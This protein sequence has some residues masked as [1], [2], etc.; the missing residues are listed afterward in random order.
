MYKVTNI[1]Q[2]VTNIVQKSNKYSAKSNKYS[3]KSNKYS[4]KSNKYSEKSNKY[5]ANCNKYNANIHVTTKTGAQIFRHQNNKKQKAPILGTQVPRY[6]GTRP[7]R[8]GK[9]DN[10]TVQRARF[11]STPK[12]WL[13]FQPPKEQNKRWLIQPPRWLDI[14]PPWTIFLDGVVYHYSTGLC[15]YTY[16]YP[17]SPCQCIIL[18]HVIAPCYFIIL[19]HHIAPW[20]FIM[21]LHHVTTKQDHTGSKTRSFTS[22]LNHMEQTR[23]LP[24]LSMSMEPSRTKSCL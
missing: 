4:A 20:Y 17:I 5:C 12:R 2:K 9:K 15:S 23:T 13:D 19:L 3:T 7:G 8:Y 21:V 14:Q 22:M 16:L 24:A 1:V 11:L 18:H 10:L 6:L